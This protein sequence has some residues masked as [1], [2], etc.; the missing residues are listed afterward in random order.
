MLATGSKT[1]CRNLAVR[2]RQQLQSSSSLQKYAF[3][4][5]AAASA[6]LAVEEMADKVNLQGR[7]VLVR[8]DLN[9]PLDE[10]NQVL[11]DSR[12]RAIL[13]TTQFLRERGANVILCSSFGQHLQ[14]NSGSSLAP[15]VQPLEQLLQTKIW[16][17]NDCVGPEVQAAAKQLTAQGSQSQVVLLENT[18]MHPGES[19]NS[20]EFSQQLASVADYYVNEAFS[21]VEQ[22]H[23]SSAGVAQHMKLCATGYVLE[24]ELQ[25]VAANGNAVEQLPG[26]AALTETYHARR[27][28]FWSI[29]FASM[30]GYFVVPALLE[31]I[32]TSIHILH[33]AH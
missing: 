25:L 26:V 30:F 23:A 29:S 20:P 18:L 24:Q 4:A 11:D 5:S 1:L 14:S 3:H 16:K 22:A 8:V 6:K 9:A 17:L 2:S 33:L 27:F 28:P 10:N 12:L 31:N 19:Q 15:V 32:P 13:P 21:S 7:K